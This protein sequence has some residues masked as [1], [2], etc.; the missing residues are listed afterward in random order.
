MFPTEKLHALNVITMIQVTLLPCRASGFRALLCLCVLAIGMLTPGVATAQDDGAEVVYLDQA[1]SKDDRDWYYHFSQGSAFVSY[2]V[3]INLEASDSDQLLRTVLNSPRFGL[4]PD[5][6]SEYNPDGLP[7]GVNKTTLAKPVGA[8]PAGDYLGI[9][10]AACHENQLQ[11]RGKRVRITGGNA[12]NIDLQ[13]LVHELDN[14]LQAHLSDTAKF[15]RLAARLG[16]ANPDAASVLRKRVEAEQT[17]I[18][19]YGSTFAVT[20]YPWGPG[21]LDALTMIA[22]RSTSILTGIHENWSPGIAPVKPPFLWNA[23]HG[24]WTQWSATV[25]DPIRRNFGETMGVFLPVDLK[26]KSPAEGLFD[27]NAMIKDLQRVEQQLRRLAPPSWPENVLGKIDRDKAKVGK[28]LFVEHCAGCHG[29]WPYRW[30]EPNDLGK[31]FILVGLLPQEY[32]GTDRTQSHAV[33]PFALTG[34]LAGYLPGELRGKPL[35][36]TM[37]FS[38]FLGT[39]TMEK[40]LRGLKL[41]DAEQRDLHGYHGTS[42]APTPEG[43]WKAAP[44]DGVWATAPFL[45]NGSV[46]N[47]YEMLVPAAQRT[48]K[49]QLGGD[50]DPVKVGFDT[51]AISGTF[52]MDT[53][54]PGNSNSGHSFEN[55]P[56]GNG[57]IG[58]LLTDEQRWALVEYLKSIPETPGRV[59][60]FGGPAAN[61]AK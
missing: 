32:M 53:T 22:D 50:F 16:A 2:D 21:R 58:P 12:T 35:I 30:T 51:T 41:T 44:R 23:P 14:A 46:P 10:C 40:A 3:F 57:I 43:V 42:S 17:R 56:R 47:L 31:S 34:E 18:H 59:T 33:R 38:G 13:V 8:W 27:S 11:Y 5:V 6:V 15:G 4:I 26:S 49:F 25:R 55:G 36:P 52:L 24:L 20:P 60:P 9:N 39:M 19:N 54:L 37:A 7:V 45:H 48:R 61:S 28:G 1:W 29:A